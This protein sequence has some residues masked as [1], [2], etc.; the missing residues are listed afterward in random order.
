MRSVLQAVVEHAERRPEQ[1]AIQLFSHRVPRGMLRY[2]DVAERAAAAATWF[3]AQGIGR[4]KTV[5]LIGEADLAFH[6]VWFGA[7]WVGA[8]PMVLPD[9]SVRMDREIYCT[10]LAFILAYA[11]VDLLALSSR[12]DLGSYLANEVKIATYDEI[13]EEAP[14]PPAMHEPEEGEPIILQHSSGTTGT[15]KGIV[16]THG[17]V[18]RQLER[19]V[20]RSTVDH[21]DVVANWLPLYHDLGMVACYM[22]SLWA[23]ATLIWMSPFEWVA[24]PE[25]L[26]EAASEFGCTFALMPNFA[27]AVLTHSVD[28]PSRYDLS[29]FRCLISGGEPLGAANMQAFARHFAAAGLPAA[30]LQ[31]GY[32][33]AESVCVVACSGPGV[34]LKYHRIVTRQ[35]EQHHRAV[36]A[37]KDADEREVTVHVSNATPL[38]DCEIRVVDDDRR[39][40]PAGHAGRILVRT[41]FLFDG[42]YRRDDL[43][44]GLIDDDGYYDSGDVG[45]FDESGHVYV[46]GRIKDLV[47]IGGRNVYAHDVEEVA[48]GV[49]GVHPGRT[50]CF[51]VT[52]ASRGTEGAVLL[53]ESDEP[54]AQWPVLLEHV[55]AAV[56]ANADVDLADARI[57]P[58]GALRKSTAGKLAR[59]GNRSAYLEGRFGPPARLVTGGAS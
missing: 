31:A 21:N 32:G 42:Y 26:L 36:P 48:N 22:C 14:R 6:G 20:E 15:P 18:A 47:I 49:P 50:V 30:A 29:S 58:R 59:Q 52:I 33:M 17:M 43:N 41:P 27:F 53:F 39:P 24:N 7:L 28:D 23:G 11:E 16:L 3:R 35:W 2:G 9:P 10:R 40:L 57:V 44:E 13:V 1:V 38:R 12:V 4:G 8:L 25:L 45:Y 46:T 55:R 5:A 54:E 51:A 19:L 34:P 56:V 37:E